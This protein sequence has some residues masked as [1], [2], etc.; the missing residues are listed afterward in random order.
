VEQPR[1]LGARVAPHNIDAEEAVIACCLI[2]PEASIS[3]CAEAGIKADSFYRPAHQVI[4]SSI[5]S[6]NSAGSGIDQIALADYLASKPLGS[7]PGRERDPDAK[8]NLLE[9]VGG[10]VALNRITSRIE[11]TVHVHLWADIVVEKWR[12]RLLLQA[13]SKAEESVYTGSAPLSDTVSSLL[14]SVSSCT[15]SESST[16]E[17]SKDLAPKAI[18]VIEER[19]ASPRRKE[20]PSTGITKLDQIIDFLPGELI[21]IAGR[22]GLGKTSLAVTILNSFA[23]DGHIPSVMFSL[24]TQNMPL[25]QKLTFLRARVMASRMRDGILSSSDIVALRRASSEIASAN[26][27][28]DEDSGASVEKIV[29][30]SASLAAKWAAQGMALGVVVV[31]YLQLV[32]GRAAKGSVRE[33]EVASVSRGLK[34]MAMK[35]SV[36]V[37]GLAQVGRES[38]KESRRPRLRDLR[39]SGSLEQDADRVV[40]IHRQ[41]EKDEQDPYDSG[42]SPCLQQELIIAKNR[43]GES[44]RIIPVTFNRPISRFENFAADSR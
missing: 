14:S 27:C 12:Q 3:A 37:I 39:E 36:P 13:I 10:H 28:F 6:L 31:D 42:S 8:M 7:I 34:A 18:T 11:S 30:R 38:E 4:Y 1:I 9:H 19:N 33:Q 29:A 17:F 20:G 16:S 40:F 23:V 2:D 41:I 44:G 22:P 35:L 15:A 26:I 21:I 32:G 43:N 5:I 25:M 24:E